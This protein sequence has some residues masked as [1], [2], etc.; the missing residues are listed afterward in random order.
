MT[1]TLEPY[2][3]LINSTSL[4]NGTVWNESSSFQIYFNFNF[5]ISGQ[6][7]TALNVMAGGGLSFAGLG[8]KELL[9][10][11]TP[12]GGYLLKDKGN[13]IS[14]S[15][16][17]YEI[18]GGAGEHILKVEWKNAG[19]VQW[20]TTSNNNDYVDM[21][22]WLFEN[23]NHIEIHFGN[24]QTNPG[25]YGYPDAISDPNPG[26][27]VKF[28]FDACSNVLCPIGPANLPSYGFYNICNPDYY[29]IDGTPSNGI[30]YNF[31]PTGTADIH[32]ISSDKISI[33]PNPFSE[34]LTLSFSEEQKNLTIT[35]TDLFGK[36]IKTINFSGYQQTIEKG[37]MTEGVYFIQLKDGENV[38]M[39]KKVIVQ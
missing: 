29:F 17:N 10:Y 21:Q 14:I 8:F 26:P 37:E 31:Y 34:Q 36:I 33:Y 28:W 23:D 18:S 9:I 27:S 16:I 1:T 22:V 5:I 6:T 15:Q 2:Q 13:P 7:Y 11:H 38:L 3:P 35:V 30:T 19:F 39:T 20:Y 25:T 12:F 24:N 32:E 4:N